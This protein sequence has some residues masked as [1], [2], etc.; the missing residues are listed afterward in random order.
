MNAVPTTEPVKISPSLLKS[1][2][3][4]F[5][6]ERVS[7]D[8]VDLMTYAYDAT[9]HHYPPQVVV[10]AETAEEISGLMKLACEYKVPVY[11]R[12]GGTGHTGGALALQGGILLSMERM[13]AIRSIDADN[14]LVTAQTG[15]PLGSL[16]TAVQKEGLFY[17]PDPSSA[18]TASLGG[19]LA[20]CAGGLN[21]VKYGTT[22]DWIQSLEAVLPT[23]EIIHLGSKARKNVVSFNLV[24]LLI[25]SEGILAVITEATLR[26]IPYPAHRTTFIALF[27]SV[28]DS[29]Q[30]VRAILGSGALPCALEFIDRLS[31][32][33]AN[34]HNPEAGLPIAEALLLIEIDGLDPADVQEDKAALIE[35]CQSKGAVQITEADD[36]QERERLWDIRRSL[37]PAMF[38]KAPFKTNEDICVPISA[39]PAML[40][41]AYAISRKY[42]VFALCFGHAGDGNLHV[43][44]M[45]HDE[46]DPKV[47]QAV[48]E[49]FQRTVSLN[50]SISGEHGVG[51]SKA[52]YLSYE[53]GKR[54][55]QLL[56]DIKR[57]FDPHNILNPGKIVTASEEKR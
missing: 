46:Q 41:H 13:A 35:I 48:D 8:P 26:L 20:E 17:P 5:T 11:P 2:K 30:A 1:L 21:C 37:S 45:S 15:I 57:V 10:W 54:E 25:G 31:L 33:A 7:N 42:G 29:A 18:K 53:M 27:D 4:V 28:D 12:G 56:L 52:P 6:P 40:E 49:L 34:A 38:A 3:K 22:K 55:Q 36:D 9:R 39:F 51:I 19:T 32:E 16:K 14:R 23:G 44:F 24:Q 50:G 47:E 43:N